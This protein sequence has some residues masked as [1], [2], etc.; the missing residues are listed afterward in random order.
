M[1]HLRTLL[2]DDDV[3]GARQ[4]ARLVECHLGPTIIVPDVY[5]ALDRL[6]GEHFDAVVL[7]IALP[8]A[9]GIDLLERLVFGIPAVVLTWLVSPAIAARALGAGAHA[10]LSKPC[11]AADLV[12][13]VRAAIRPRTVG[14][15]ATL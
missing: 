15:L 4:L 5:Q 6:T 11:P 10:V 13:A 1:N 12:A 3:D 2:V 14:A 7:E 8:G 9:S